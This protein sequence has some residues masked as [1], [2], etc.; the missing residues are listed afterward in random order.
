MSKI[1]DAVKYGIPIYLRPYKE[2]KVWG[3]GGIGEYWY[4]AEP[5]E[6]SS[7][8]V[9]NGDTMPM[10]EI[11]ERTPEKV[12]GEDVISAFGKTLPLVKILT[13]RGRLSVQFHDAKNELWIVT[14]IDRSLA[15]EFPVLI[16]GF[17]NESI[18]KCGKEIKD[19]YRQDLEGYGKALNELIDELERKGNKDLLNKAG[20]VILAGRQFKDKD[21]GISKLFNQLLAARK[22]INNYYNFIKVKTGDVIPVPQ[23]TLHALGPG[24]EVIEPQIPGETRS[25]EDGATYPVRYHFPDYPKE[26]AERKLDLDRIGEMNAGAW[27]RGTPDII[28]QTDAVK[29]ERLPGGFEDKGMEA[30]RITISKDAEL[31]YDAVKS[32]H[33]L[34][35]ING[36]AE[37]VIDDTHYNIPKAVPD[38]Q[39]LLI[40]ASSANYKVIA[41]EDAQLIDTFTPV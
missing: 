36:I 22:C 7:I 12:L 10:A 6:K 41:K 15:G 19:K 32:F 26:T 28:D 1:I 38:G 27:K 8:A 33:T 11:M 13:P 18:K 4:G 40:P 20:D 25:L 30:R 14:G 17:N 24:I 34:V 23:G 2:P 21:E 31:S 5:G 35:A 37:A 9:V 29:V 3:V 39:M 16:V